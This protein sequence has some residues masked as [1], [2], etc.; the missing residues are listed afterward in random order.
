MGHSSLPF[1]AVDVEAFRLEPWCSSARPQDLRQKGVRSM[2][3]PQ[4][5]YELAAENSDRLNKYYVLTPGIATK[6]PDIPLVRA[7]KSVA[8]LKG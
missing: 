1:S 2:V 5:N 3:H 8:G 6:A 4:A 7:E